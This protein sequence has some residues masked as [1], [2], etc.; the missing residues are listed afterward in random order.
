MRAED[1]EPW[2][3]WWA[4]I[5]HRELRKT[6]AMCGFS[7]NYVTPVIETLRSGAA[8]VDLERLLPTLREGFGDPPDED[9][10]GSCA[11]AVAL[12]WDGTGYSRMRFGAA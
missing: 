6:L 9:A 12:W 1:R 2:D 4:G 7:E 11:V 10:D 8:V 5:G 3:Q